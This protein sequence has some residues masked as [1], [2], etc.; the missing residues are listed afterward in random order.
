MTK[1]STVGGAI[2]ILGWPF[3]KKGWR[4]KKK[5]GGQGGKKRVGLGMTPSMLAKKE[6]SKK[7]AK[8]RGRGETKEFR[9]DRV[10]VIPQEGEGVHVP[11]LGR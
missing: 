6:N 3:G 9:L 2:K 7:N 10:G 5:G 11:T 1:E 4:N 8:K